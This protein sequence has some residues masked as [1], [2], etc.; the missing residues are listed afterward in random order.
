MLW[1]RLYTAVCWG[2]FSSASRG[3]QPE[4]T[5][6]LHP[7][8]EEFIISLGYLGLLLIVYEGGLRTSFK[9]LNANL[10]RSTLVALTGID[11]PI[12]LSS[13]LV[14]LLGA[15]TLQVLLLERLCARLVSVQRSLFSKQWTCG[16]RLGVMLTSPA[17]INGVFGVILCLHVMLLEK[18]NSLQA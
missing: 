2:K 9:S 4:Q 16:S 3:Q 18:V 17:M 10:L 5:K 12:G 13:V 11:I 7:K 8:A 6:L 1:I 14:P 15:T